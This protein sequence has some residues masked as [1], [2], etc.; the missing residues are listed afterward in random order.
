MDIE[1]FDEKQDEMQE[2]KEAAHGLRTVNKTTVEL[3]WWCC[4]YKYGTDD[5][6]YKEIATGKKYRYDQFGDIALILSQL[7][8][9][10]DV[11]FRENKH[12]HD[13]HKSA[14]ELHWELPWIFEKRIARY[15]TLLCDL[16]I[17]EREKGKFHYNTQKYTYRL[18]MQHPI[19]ISMYFNEALAQYLAEDRKANK[20]SYSE[21]LLYDK[22]L[23][24]K[25]VEFAQEKALDQNG[26]TRWTEMVQQLDRNGTTGVPKWSNVTNTTQVLHSYYSK[27]NALQK[28]SAWDES[29]KKTSSSIGSPASFCPRKK[30][31]SDHRTEM[32]QCQSGL[33]NTILEKLHDMEKAELDQIRGLNV[34][35]WRKKSRN[36][37]YKNHERR[38]QAK[39][40]FDGLDAESKELVEAFQEEMHSGNGKISKDYSYNCSLVD[41][42]EHAPNFLQF[43]LKRME[44]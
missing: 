44:A 12:K 40:W 1:N 41:A 7:K 43:I 29:I 14:A 31:S 23:E 18:N 5:E 28:S 33:E 2:I 39:G 4:L 9:W 21:A 35:Q 3:L 15:L 42:Q 38:E 13:F 36:G 11:K 26:T 8:Y 37:Y 25:V 27:P 22:N 16:E 24:Q 6:T 34:G 30:F 32:V 17:I 19:V 20:Q 10:Q